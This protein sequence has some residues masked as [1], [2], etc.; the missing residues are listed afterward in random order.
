MIPSNIIDQLKES[1]MRIYDT[2]VLDKWKF[3]DYTISIAKELE[4]IK[5]EKHKTFLTP[6]YLK[7]DK[8]ESKD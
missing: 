2:D 1:W 8:R 7:D 3:W 5:Q 6:G 4:V